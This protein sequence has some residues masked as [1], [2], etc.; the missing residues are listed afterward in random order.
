M[1]CNSFSFVCICD[2]KLMENC[3]KCRKRCNH[4]LKN[5]KNGPSL[6]R[7]HILW[8]KNDVKLLHLTSAWRLMVKRHVDCSVQ[9]QTRVVYISRPQQLIFFATASPLC[10][11]TWNEKEVTFKSRLNTLCRV[12]YVLQQVWVEFYMNSYHWLFADSLV[13]IGRL[14]NSE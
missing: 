3:G 10:D 6:S 2:G 5:I 7:P 8:Y 4:V 12:L 14:V 9:T 11:L 1:I 13:E